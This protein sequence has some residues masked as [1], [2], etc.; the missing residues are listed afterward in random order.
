M[1]PSLFLLF[2][3]G[4]ATASCSA[5]T[6]P[7][8][9]VLLAQNATASK[10][11]Q[12]KAGT[13]KTANAS[14]WGFDKSDS[15]AALQAAIDSHVPTLIIDNMGSPWILSKTVNLTSD[16]HIILEDG[17]VIEAMKG[18]FHGKSDALFL[19]KALHDEMI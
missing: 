12:V 8:P 15:T 19:G 17:V 9:K 10:V 1:K 18:Q 14:W 11:A 7:A 3:V 6:P 2:T 4:S 5:A 16:Q 13:L